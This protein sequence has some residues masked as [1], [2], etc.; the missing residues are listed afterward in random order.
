[1]KHV[2]NVKFKFF[3]LLGPHNSDFNI[4]HPP[5]EPAKYSFK[6]IRECFGLFCT[7]A[8]SQCSCMPEANSK[9]EGDPQVRE[10][11]QAIEQRRNVK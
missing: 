3:Y 5:M 4:W 11:W 2:F 8:S 9:D 6:S 1:M 7:L 10:Q